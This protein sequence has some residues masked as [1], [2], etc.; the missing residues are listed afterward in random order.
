MAKYKPQHARLL[1]IDRK[2]REGKYPN[3]TT[4]AEE[5]EVSRKTIQRD[6]EYLRYQLDA[7]I[8][9]APG[10]RGY[11]Y[12]EDQYKLPAINIRES[13][14][15]AVYL[16]EK[17]LVQY[18]GTPVYES[19]CSVFEKIENSLPS[20][21]SIDGAADQA[22]FTVLPPF[23][24]TIIPAVWETVTACLRS[25]QRVLIHYRTPGKETS[26]REIDPYHAV[27]YEGDW[28]VVGYCHMRDEIRTFSMS[29]ILSAK[30]KEEFFQ[31]PGD[32]DFK[33]HAG[34]HFGVHW[35]QEDVRVRI[36]FTRQVS[37]YVLERK[38]HPS[39]EIEI[40]DDGSLVLSMT[41]NHLL[42]LKKWVLSWGDMAKVLEPASF[43]EDVRLTLARAVALY[44][45]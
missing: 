41:V 4:L 38:W 24:T 23:S 20:K 14:L 26:V 40:R 22:K 21:I 15:F 28:Y 33:E 34:S 27:R 3:C 2:I 25:S 29:R 30:R 17:L 7:P 44:G 18:E 43:A 42:E 32:F 45:G 8:E 37:D 16:A 1:F 31:I 36:L 6:I 35:G 10:E 5:W 9:Y 12:T 11:F 19:L 13:D 39:Q